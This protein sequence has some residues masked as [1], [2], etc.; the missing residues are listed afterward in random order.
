MRNRAER[1]WQRAVDARLQRSLQGRWQGI[2]VF[3]SAIIALLLDLSWKLLGPWHWVT[4][5]EEP[6]AVDRSALTDPTPDWSALRAEFAAALRRKLWA[7]ASR[8]YCG[9]GLQD[10][11]D[12]TSVRSHFRRLRRK[13]S[14]E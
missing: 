6:F 12:L 2:T 1:D 4:N 5:C 8:H 10:F 13:D 3:M 14:L 11:A 7:N 9:R